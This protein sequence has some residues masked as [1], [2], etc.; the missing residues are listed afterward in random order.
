MKHLGKTLQN[1]RWALWL[2]LLFVAIMPFLLTRPL[3]PENRAFINTG[4][5]GDTIGGLTAPFVGIMG[6][7]LLYLALR[8]QIE[9]N[10]Q[11][12][13]ESRLTREK[14]ELLFY[15]SNLK[16]SID[17]FRFGDNTPGSQSIQEQFNEF[18][19]NYH[20]ENEEDYKA[21]SS[22]TELFHILTIFKSLLER[23]DHTGN[24]V[25]MELTAHQFNFRVFPGLI[26]IYDKM[27][28]YR[29]DGCGKDHG[30]PKDFCDLVRGVKEKL[31]IQHLNV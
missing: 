19:C 27:D 6:A 11:M 8:A 25:I 20:P 28:C 18:Y 30:L 21:N 9:A 31:E 13:K 23:L 24:Q 5:I 12:D 3:S 26:D 7:I 2:G 4:E 22:L 14:E 29:C 10:L 17:N 16:S 1:A 15:Y